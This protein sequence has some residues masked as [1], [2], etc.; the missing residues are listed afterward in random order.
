MK[1]GTEIDLLILR[2]QKDPKNNTSL[3]NFAIDMKRPYLVNEIISRDV[4]KQDENFVLHIL[5][6]HADT[7]YLNELW[8]LIE[9]NHFNDTDENG[10]Y[11]LHI[12]SKSLKPNVIE[13]M[14][15]VLK[16]FPQLKER[17]S[18]MKNRN[19]DT[20]LK[21]AIREG[22]TK[23]AMALMSDKN[24]IFST[25][26][27]DNALYESITK[28]NI[29]LIEFITERFPNKLS[30][31]KEILIHAVEK[32]FLE[33][34]EVILSSIN[35]NTASD[36][37]NYI[38]DDKKTALFLAIEADDHKLIDLFL[39]HHNNLDFSAVDNE[40]NTALH[41][42]AQ[43]S[44]EFDVKNMLNVLNDDTILNIQ[45]CND[46]TALMKAIEFGKIHTFNQIL[47]TNC[48]R[49]E[50]TNST[51][52]NI[53]HLI[54][55]F[56]MNNASRR[57]MEKSCSDGD[58]LS[59]KTDNDDKIPLQYMGKE[60]NTLSMA[61]ILLSKECHPSEI[62]RH[63]QMEHLMKSLCNVELE[64]CLLEDSNFGSILKA[65]NCTEKSIA[66]FATR[67][68]RVN[69]LTELIKD[70]SLNDLQSCVQ[71]ATK[72]QKYESLRTF[73]RNKIPIA[74]QLD[75]PQIDEFIKKSSVEAFDII[76]HF[77]SPF[78]QNTSMKNK[79]QLQF[80][81]K[82]IL[83]NYL[84]GKREIIGDNL[85]FFSN[86]DNADLLQFV[87][88][89]ISSVILQD[90]GPR[91]LDVSRKWRHLNS[92]N[93][94]LKNSNIFMDAKYY[95][96]M[97]VN[98]FS[99][100]VDILIIMRY[101]QL[102]EYTSKNEQD[103]NSLLHIAVQLQKINVVEY[104]LMNNATLKEPSLIP[105]KNKNGEN[106]VLF[107]LKHQ[108]KFFSK[109]LPYAT[110]ND[111][112]EQDNEGRS[113]LH[114]F[115]VRSDL[116]NL[117]P[118]DKEISGL[119]N[120]DSNQDT[121]LA[122]C[123]STGNTKM[124]MKLIDIGASL[125]NL[126]KE[127][128]NVL[129]LCSKYNNQKVAS[130]AVERNEELLNKPDG[131]GDYPQHLSVTTNQTEMLSFFLKQ[132]TLK[133]SSCNRNGYNALWLA[134][135]LNETLVMDFF[136]FEEMKKH[137][138][139]IEDLSKM[140]NATNEKNLSIVSY[141]LSSGKTDMTIEH[142]LQ[143]WKG[144]IDVSIKDING[145]TSLHIAVVA[146]KRPKIIQ[147]ILECYECPC[148]DY[149]FTRFEVNT[150]TPFGF[151]IKNLKNSTEKE[152]AKLLLSHN[153]ECGRYQ[154]YKNLEQPQVNEKLIDG[155]NEEYFVLLL[156]WNKS[157]RANLL[158]VAT[159]LKNMKLL[160]AIFKK[161]EVAKNCLKIGL[162][163]SIAFAAQERL[164]EPLNFLLYKD[165]S[166]EDVLE[167]LMKDKP[168]LQTALLHEAAENDCEKIFKWILGGMT[169]DRLRKMVSYDTG[170]ATIFHSIAKG[171]TQEAFELYDK[172]MKKL[173]DLK[174]DSIVKE[175]LE[176]CD[177]DGNSILHVAAKE[178]TTSAKLRIVT[179]LLEKGVNPAVKNKNDDTFLMMSVGMDQKLLEHVKN[180]STEWFSHLKE[181]QEILSNF[182][183]LKN[184][185]IFCAILRKFMHPD[186]QKET[187]HPM[188]LLDKI[189]DQR[190]VLKDSK[191][192]LLIWEAKFH[193]NYLSE[194]KV[195]CNKYRKSDPGN[196]NSKSDRAFPIYT[197]LE[198]IVDKPLDLGFYAKRVFSFPFIVLLILKILDFATDITLNVEYYEQPDGLFQD[199]PNTSTCINH[200]T[201]GC[202]FTGVNPIDD[203]ILFYVSLAIFIITFLA[204][205]YFVMTYKG[206]MHYRSIL[207]GYCCPE[208]MMK[209]SKCYTFRTWIKWPAWIFMSLVNQ[210]TIF[211][212]GLFM[213]TFIEY[214]RPTER[215]KPELDINQHNC[216]KCKSCPAI[217]QCIC[218]FCN[219]NADNDSKRTKLKREYQQTVTISK[220]ITSATENSLM[221]L[222]QLS[223]LFPNVI[224]LFPKEAVDTSDLKGNIIFH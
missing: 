172:M 115:A 191:E 90:D 122:L 128:S 98:P 19:G 209:N 175:L 146:Q 188:D 74:D 110:G 210:I 20:P 117:F 124:A 54:V 111:L 219:R 11:V 73:I 202:H 59:T 48:I 85:E 116:V 83:E 93:V 67:Y 189:W 3:V 2:R 45:N 8:D 221:P 164:L 101:F 123:I 69:I 200:F 76:K 129:H 179:S 142:L 62:C 170:S 37:L 138:M 96:E 92:L 151:T 198:N 56:S 166:P 109:I 91:V 112:G 38:N 224:Q 72:E 137:F 88:D 60:R 139:D 40:K 204:D 135:M 134:L 206:T 79:L 156:K 100:D 182:I 44:Q 6:K 106:V 5:K 46:E 171:K 39:Q 71:L 211:A 168:E 187:V 169:P 13:S 186:L 107:A 68:E 218:I 64:E 75:V 223:L 161:E 7:S 65:W 78:Q 190:D 89:N 28:R 118:D 125:E 208:N 36:L 199:F 136:K 25:A 180:M 196:E 70:I 183:E 126:T 149:C 15:K 29:K 4:Y 94:L 18:D 86:F 176:K 163:P 16:R 121:A 145:K 165:E 144:L 207:L 152:N 141:A 103:G 193:K 22:N 173:K 95:Q 194:L 133:I 104:I 10:D 35:E 31:S 120:K 157:E 114:I 30:Q 33:G 177:T 26:S 143:S 217:D 9:Q 51:N 52:Q 82:T 150:E 80:S 113:T 42:I 184:D 203:L 61:E 102:D 212:Y 192:Q 213:Q 97:R 215:K 23:A 181:N 32:R 21:I 216:N 127:K 167:D 81:T 1:Y 108:N 195:C 158:H 27:R 159:Q 77:L 24:F 14:E 222:V 43:Y 160:E 55:K 119:D 174:D 47:D 201:I 84:I 50:L 205:F 197:M 66:W 87:V 57:I 131:N 53:L 162:K 140:I 147:L 34:A 130:I 105:I 155:L 153:D 132:G 12:M 214:W 220:V 99:L 63:S 148:S 17:S 178:P 41:L 58:C 49:F 185:P 154:V